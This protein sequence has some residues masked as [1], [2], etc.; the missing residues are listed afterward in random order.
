MSSSSQFQSVLDSGVRNSSPKVHADRIT[1]RRSQSR[2]RDDEDEEVVVPR[3]SQ[4]YRTS[5]SAVAPPVRMKKSER[6]RSVSPGGSLISSGRSRSK[7]P[8]NRRSSPK[9]VTYDERVTVRHSDT[10]DSIVTDLSGKDSSLELSPQEPASKPNSNYLSV[11]SGATSDDGSSHASQLRQTCH[12][13]TDWYSQ[14][15]S[16]SQHSSSPGS[17]MDRLQVSMSSYPSHSPDQ[18]SDFFTSSPGRGDSGVY[19]D[20]EGAAKRGKINI[21]K[22]YNHDRTI[23]YRMAIKAQYSDEVKRM[24]S[25]NI[26]EIC[27]QI[28][29][30]SRTPV[31]PTSDIG[32][33]TERS[34][35]LPSNTLTESDRNLS[36]HKKSVSSSIGNF[37][38][39][40]SPRMSRRDGRRDKSGRSSSS[41]SAQSLDTS[42]STESSQS[43]EQSRSKGRRSF[44]KVLGRSRSRSQSKSSGHEDDGH[45]NKS[46]KSTEIHGVSE[47][48][49]PGSQPLPDATHRILKSIEQNKGSEK[50]VYQR[51]KER[52]APVKPG[53]RT[54]PAK[55]QALKASPETS[56]TAPENSSK[57]DSVLNKENQLNDSHPV[58]SS[59]AIIYPEPA[60]VHPPQ[61]LNVKPI[62]KPP[63]RIVQQSYP[64]MGSCDESIGECS[65]D[66]NLEGGEP[67]LLNSSGQASVSGSKQVILSQDNLLDLCPSNTSSKGYRDSAP[68]RF[69]PPPT[70]MQLSHG[71]PLVGLENGALSKHSSGGSN[72]PRLS[73]SCE[74]SPR[75][76][77]K[78]PSY[79][80]LSCAVSGYG[81]Y[82]SYSSRKDINLSSPGASVS[83][84]HSDSSSPDSL[85][86]SHVTRTGSLPV[87]FNKSHLAVVKPA[88]QVNGQISGVIPN[89]HAGVY[90]TGDV[91]KDGQYYLDL[92]Q[93]EEERLLVLCGQAKGDMGETALPEEANGRI[94]AAIGKTN[95]LISK[96]FKQFR[97]L[98]HKHMKPDGAER[99]TKWE[100][101]Q[102][103]WDM[104]KLQIDD[105]DELFAEIAFMRQNEWKDIPIRSTRSSANSSPKSA[106]L[107]LSSTPSQTPG[108]TPSQTPGHTPGHTPAARRKPVNLKDT[109]DSSPEKSLKAKQTAKAREDARK[110]LLAEKRAA[111]KQQRL[112]AQENLNPQE[113]EIFL[114]DTSKK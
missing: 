1:R 98:C 53:D 35:T 55:S 96:K 24:A 54:P 29:A 30:G 33:R 114:A 20:G 42:G 90:P 18:S 86:S 61:S 112:K 51:F 74:I 56:P 101:L 36:V 40:I 79:L 44:L 47:L 17:T 52:Q 14:T 6:S 25:A 57:S 11:N 66:I 62:Q 89:G 13:I 9:H 5:L 103:F 31:S 41:G 75:D 7:S 60:K 21:E 83:S 27:P 68:Q 48:T 26:Q 109:P 92:C 100:D 58:V 95:L 110:R 78:M 4:P 16:P 87:N 69:S 94:R 22:D 91:Y 34:N 43:M 85:P 12:Q 97:G 39:K 84:V 46:P 10:D 65:L 70:D 28:T 76:V 111:M 23:S 38:R 19:T 99:P 93:T 67:A 105:L 108:H 104:V 71:A 88:G 15:S 45:L 72:M 107:S 102:G 63:V 8:G 113:V 50:T 49:V 77:N 64:S 81:R 32:P 73:N 2:H 3:V 106:S 37:F 80:K 82:S 59:P